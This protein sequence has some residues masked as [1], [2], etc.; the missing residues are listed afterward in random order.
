MKSKWIIAAIAASLL[1]GCVIV[2]EEHDHHRGWHYG[3]AY[4]YHHSERAGYRYG[5]RG[6]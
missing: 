4:G 1:G 6:W 2:P 3:G 5:H